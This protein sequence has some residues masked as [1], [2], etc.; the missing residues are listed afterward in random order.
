MAAMVVMRV[1]T[2]VCKTCGGCGDSKVGDDDVF[3]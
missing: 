2:H 1:Q 3:S